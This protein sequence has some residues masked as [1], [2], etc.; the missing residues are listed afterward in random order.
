V[1]LDDI[2]ATF[3]KG[4][5]IGILGLNG[6][7]KST[8]LRLIGG[9]EPPDRGTIRRNGSISWPIAFTGGFPKT[10]TGRE[11][12]RFVSRL[13]G[14]EPG[15][16]EAFTESF[17]ELGMFFDMQV[18]TYS[19]G[20][21]ARLGFAVSMAISFD[22]YL[23]DEATEAGDWRFKAKCLR[24]FRERGASA[25]IIMVSHNEGTIRRICDMGA[26]L[27]G[28]KLRFYED[29]TEAIAVYSYGTDKVH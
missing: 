1:V 23:V 7:G 16:I 28:G 10:L 26:V 6:A 18:R 14:A 20:M 11:S 2:S 29:I 5:K 22:C 21:R 19:S 9:M 24:A 17:A 3:P 12:A 27:A 15:E 4:R 13:Y 25:T 8:L